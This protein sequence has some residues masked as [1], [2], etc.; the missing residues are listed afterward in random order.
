[1]HNL[2][3]YSKGAQFF[4]FN[5]KESTYSYFFN[6]TDTKFHI[7]GSKNDNNSVHWYTEFTWCFSKVVF[8]RGLYD[9]VLDTNGSLSISGDTSCASPLYIRVA[10]LARVLNFWLA[11]LQTLFT[12]FSIERLESIVIPSYTCP[13]SDSIFRIIWN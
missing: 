13:S 4:I 3:G 10:V 9:L 7:F 1:M 5:L 2:H 12:C 6:P 11:F 8:L